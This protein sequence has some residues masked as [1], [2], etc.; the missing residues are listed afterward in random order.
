MHDILHARGL[1]ISS[2]MLSGIIDAD[3]KREPMQM[4][5]RKMGWLAL[6]IRLDVFR[7]VQTPK[8]MEE[9]IPRTARAMTAPLKAGPM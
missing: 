4:S 1:A 6:T 8:K 3:M 5:T 7:R 9:R 2:S